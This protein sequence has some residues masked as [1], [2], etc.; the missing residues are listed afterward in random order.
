MTQQVK[1]DDIDVKILHALIKDAREK[2]KD[3]AHDVG[4]SSVAVFKRIQRLKR[5]GVIIE[6]TIF[7]GVELL[8]HP[9][10]ALV[11]VNLEG[12]N[13][14]VIAELVSKQTNLA[15]I[16]PSVGKYDLCVFAVA[17]NIS[18][19]D[20]LRRTIREK[21]GVKRA[22]INIWIKPYFNFDNFELEAT[23]E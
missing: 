17:R 9:Y 8:G 14:A 7:K 1:L 12:D 18:E 10:P 13:S 2:L 4:L 11:G 3:I 5:K 21:R 22:A 23:G 15:G 6:T 16:S 20:D 19:L